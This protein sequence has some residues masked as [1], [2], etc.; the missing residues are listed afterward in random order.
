MLYS[1]FKRFF[2]ILFSLVGIIFVIPLYILIRIAYIL[3]GDFHRIIFAQTRIGKN[4]KPFKMYKFRTMIINADEE[5]K[6]LLKDKKLKKEYELSHKLENDP[7]ITKVGK[8]IRCTS[9]DEFPQFINI[10]L[11]QMSVV[12][13]RPYL[14]R[15]KKDMGK[16]FSTIVKTKPGLTGYWQA[17]LRSR[18]NFKERIRMDVYYSEHYSFILDTKIFFKTFT[19]IFN[20]SNAK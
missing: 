8:I 20:K 18:G 3:T 16:Y 5:L 13:N 14:P 17:H 6:K 19:T 10:L 7:R 11:G 12:G 1:F 9:I 4:G 2:D 15:E